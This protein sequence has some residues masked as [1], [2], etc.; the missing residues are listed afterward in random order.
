MFVIYYF[1]LNLFD[2]ECTVNLF[3]LGFIV[4]QEVWVAKEVTT[5]KMELAGRVQITVETVCIY[6]ILMLLGKS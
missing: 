4:S 2:Q 5:W 3:M 1:I 6:F